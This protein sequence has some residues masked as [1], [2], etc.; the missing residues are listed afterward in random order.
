M[1]RSG[2]VN[3]S[4]NSFRPSMQVPRL[5]HSSS[6]HSVKDA[7][8]SSRMW[9]STAAIATSENEPGRKESFFRRRHTYSLNRLNRP[10]A[11]FMQIPLAMV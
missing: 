11:R 8:W 7:M 10:S 1:V 2:P 3:A 9:P 4:S 6:I 5:E